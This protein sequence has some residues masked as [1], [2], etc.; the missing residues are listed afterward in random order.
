MAGICSCTNTNSNTGTPSCLE[1]SG[2]VSRLFIVPLFDSNGALNSVADSDTLDAAFIT[3]KVNAADTRDRWYPISGAFVNVNQTQAEA[4][5]EDIDGTPYKVRDG[6]VAWSG[7]NVDAANERYAAT[8]NSQGCTDF[9]VYA[10]TEDY[11]LQ[12]VE[13]TDGTLL[14]PLSVIKGTWNVTYLPAS[15]SSDTVA[16][17]SIVFTFS[18]LI[19]RTKLGYVANVDTTFGTVKGLIDVNVK[20]VSAPST[21]IAVVD[22]FYDYGSFGA[23]TPY[24]GAGTDDIILVNVTEGDEVTLDS[25]VESTSVDGRYT[26]TYTGDP[27]TIADVMKVESKV[28]TGIIQST[29]FEIRET[30]LTAIA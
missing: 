27:Q 7:E 17:L 12:G 6:D 18:R 14:Y 26:L 9:G 2:I 23:K 11:K 20:S 24:V 13:S 21:T 28:T 15:N 16:K 22:M 29:G 8:L 19:D 5:T 25:V 4:V 10:L 3:A 30:N 1:S